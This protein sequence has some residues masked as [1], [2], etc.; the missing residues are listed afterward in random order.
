MSRT[1]NKRPKIAA[2]VVGSA[3]NAAIK[4]AVSEGAAL[5]EARIDTFR[6]L[7]PAALAASL[8]EIKRSSRLPII[9]TVR[10]KKEGGLGDIPG[11]ER[12]FLFNSLMKFADY[13]DIEASSSGIFKSVI[14]SAKK[15]RKKVI[16]S[17]HNFKSTPGDKKLK[18]I[19]ESALLSGAD[20]V[21][22]ATFVNSPGDL[23]RLARLFSLSDRLIVIGMGPLGAASRVF[24][25]MIGSLLTYG[26]TTGKT[27]PGQMSIRE[28]KREFSRYSL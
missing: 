24:F 6:S 23:G 13:V 1:V 18:K 3:A 9:L 28:L 16:V 19:I 10:S 11:E 25:P 14:K 2:V 26:S 8:K 5:I 17:Y 27:A 22:V 15:E 12:L 20:T 4:K 7:D 21:K